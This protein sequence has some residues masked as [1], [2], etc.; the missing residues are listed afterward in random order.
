M[1]LLIYPS[2]CVEFQVTFKFMNL[3]KLLGGLEKEEWYMNISYKN[4]AFNLIVHR[5]KT[6]IESVLSFSPYDLILDNLY[7]CTSI[8]DN[9]SKNGN[10]IK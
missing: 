7:R 10:L 1:T 4:W 8:L 6:K 2:C 5:Q 9:L 3:N